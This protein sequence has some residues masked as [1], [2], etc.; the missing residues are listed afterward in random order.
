MTLRIWTGSTIGIIILFFSLTV[1]SVPLLL[2]ISSDSFS[3]SASDSFFNKTESNLSNTTNGTVDDNN[4]SLLSLKILSDSLENRL[5]GA[6]SML[7]Y[8]ASLS[9]MRSMPNASLLNTTLETLHGIPPDSDIPKRII[10]QKVVSFYPEI[11]GISFIMPNG[12]TYFMEPYSLQSNQTKNNLAFRD[13]FKG[14]IASNDTYLGDIITSTSSGLKR[15]IIAVPVFADGVESSGV[16]TGVLVGSIDLRLL[17]KEIQSLNLSQ[18]QRIVYIDSND[19]KI[20]DSDVRHSANNDE[21]F[22]NLMSF[23]NAI[24]GKSGS[25]TEYVNQEKML[26]SYYPMDAIQNRWIIL[27]MQPINSISVN[28]NN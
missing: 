4:N 2:L 23:Q 24:E 27:L 19:T 22:S 25:L 16:L 26:V 13:Y 7:E 18:G 21:S 28:E 14:A 1:T 3:I 8:A 17:N 20:A 9:E 6:A 12:D 15:A 10:A 11:A 5:D